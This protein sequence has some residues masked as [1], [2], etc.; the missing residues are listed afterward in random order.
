[1]NHKQSSIL[2]EIF[3]EP[4]PSDLKWKDI[5]SLLRSKGAVITEGRGSR[6]RVKLN[7][8][9]G[10]FHEPHPTGKDVC[11]CTVREIRR[12]LENAGISPE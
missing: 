6:V 12:L 11:K 1:M 5:E 3:A 4:V 2:K 7:G 9:R 10:V 8:E